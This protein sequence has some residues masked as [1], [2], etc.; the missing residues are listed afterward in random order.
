MTSGQERRQPSSVASCQSTSHE[1]TH[2]HPLGPADQIA[3]QARRAARAPGFRGWPAAAVPDAQG[4]TGFQREAL[5]IHE[6]TQGPAGRAARLAHAA[7]GPRHRDRGDG[8]MTDIVHVAVLR[9]LRVR[10]GHYRY[11]RS[12]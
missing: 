12:K 3:Q 2:H 8:H 5:R 10:R 6:R 4:G 11:W 9:A 7:A 1:A